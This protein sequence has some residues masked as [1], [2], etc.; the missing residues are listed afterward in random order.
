MKGDTHGPWDCESVGLAG[1]YVEVEHHSMPSHFAPSPTRRYAELFPDNFS[2]G[3]SPSGCAVDAIMLEKHSLN[4]P[5]AEEVEKHVQTDEMSSAQRFVAAWTERKKGLDEC[6]RVFFPA[7]RWKH[8][9]RCNKEPP[10]S[11]AQ[12]PDDSEGFSH[13][14][15]GIL[16][17][18]EAL[19]TRPPGSLFKVNDDAKRR[20]GEQQE[21]PLKCPAVRPLC[22]EY[23]DSLRSLG[24]VD[25]IADAV[26][27]E[28]E[29]SH[30]MA[31]VRAHQR[32]LR[33]SRE[34]G[35]SE[36]EQLA[37]VRTPSLPSDML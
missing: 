21:A 23:W 22:K 37:P 24:V 2:R 14:R 28:K 20:Y 35:V 27:S 26:L 30:S 12:A 4:T 31:Y 36:G 8:M 29:G 7:T 33:L 11:N 10:P 25:L 13:S 6:R 1:V 3:E 17:E 18:L 32:R 9:E 16:S 34:L 5:R 19:R 15:T